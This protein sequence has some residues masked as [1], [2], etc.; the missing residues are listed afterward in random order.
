MTDHGSQTGK[1][2]LEKFA[3]SAARRAARLAAVQTLYQKE[4]EQELK[5]GLHFDEGDEAPKLDTDLLERIVRSVADR[6]ADIDSLLSGA[7]DPEWPL[8]RLELILRAILRAG[9][10]ELLENPA[11]PAPLLI[12]DYVDVA[13]AFFA[14]KEPGLVNAVLDKIAKRVR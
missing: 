4:Y 8:E 11:T 1:K 2:N 12:T 5:A 3:L 7:L 10:G 13:H 6:R 14:G 9:V